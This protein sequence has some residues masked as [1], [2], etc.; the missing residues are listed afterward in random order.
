MTQ[1]EYYGLKKPA[2]SDFVGPD[3]F[4]DNADAIDA[5][6]RALEEGKLAKDPDTGKLPESLLP[7]GPAAAKETPADQDWVTLVDTAAAGVK[8]KLLWSG[9]KATLKSYFDMLYAAASHTHPWSAITDKPSSFAPSGHAATHKTGGADAIAPADIGAALA[10]HTHAP[11]DLT[12]PVPVGKGGTG[13]TTAAAARANLGACTLAAPVTVTVSAASWAG[14]GPWTQTVTVAG[15]TAAD[16]HLA[17][18]PVDIA[19]D[20]ARKL[21]AK[22]YGC[23]AAEADSVAGGVKLTCRDAKPEI[24]FDV[25]VK[26]V[27]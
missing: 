26:G 13:A 27:R 18:L 16:A 8:K 1:T 9:V 17:V 14:S 19:D 22:A 2:T 21:Y 3:A 7:P 10:L 6:L 24:N 15:V 5:A 23:L 12:G 4:N 20:D 25:I 11:S